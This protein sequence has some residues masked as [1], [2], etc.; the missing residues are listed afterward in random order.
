ML[1]LIALR[2]RL[3]VVKYKDYEEKT[4]YDTFIFIS[5][6]VMTDRLIVYL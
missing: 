4:R 1:R 5:N 6:A 3:R 2:L